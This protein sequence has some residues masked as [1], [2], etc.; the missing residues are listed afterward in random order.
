MTTTWK[1]KAP[2]DMTQ[3]DAIS[4]VETLDANSRANMMVMSSWDEA[5]LL[6]LLGKAKAAGNVEGERM[7]Y[8]ALVMGKARAAT[9]AQASG[10]KTTAKVSGSSDRRAR[11]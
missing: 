7:T 4:Y 9:A 6:D 3:E 2:A 5:K 10:G 1:D 8:M 11:R